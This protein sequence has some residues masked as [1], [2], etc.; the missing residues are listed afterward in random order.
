MFWQNSSKIKQL[1]DENQQLVE[2]N[3]Q[4]EGTINSQLEKIEDLKAQLEQYHQDSAPND[5]N[6]L[7]ISS[8][9]GIA[10]VR[11]QLIE[12]S[13]ILKEKSQE[14]CNSNISYDDVHNTLRKTHEELSFIS[15]S[16][17][18]SH[19][20][21]TNLKGAAGEIT[22]FAE[23]INTISEQ[24]NSLALNA[25]IEAARAGEAGRGF[26]VVADEVR[27]LA[28]RAGE[29]SGEIAELVKKI[30]QDTQTTDENI[31]L[32]HSHCENLQGT[33]EQSL[34]N[35]KSVLNLSQSMH[36]TIVKEADF[37]FIQTVKIDHLSI[38]AQ[39]YKAFNEGHYENSSLTDPH[40]C[41]FGSWYY[42]GREKDKYANS[43]EFQQIEKPHQDFHKYAG[44]I[45][46]S[47]AR[48]DQNEA[49]NYFVKMEQ[50]SKEVLQILERLSDKMGASH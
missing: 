1:H 50:A 3:Q 19:D 17:K 10:E 47:A 36:E 44:K 35:I 20:S 49:R 6:N 7:L 32:T 37:S 29:A 39:V 42:D 8:F 4:Q 28:Q 24:T 15:S 30:D 14:L 43:S 11:D 21:V 22:K 25:A 12:S 48:G 18:T 33:S 34:N 2:E 41:H 5:D 9:N 38:K 16:A 13:T 46:E 27:A 23:I 31:R 40:Q 26:A 45:L